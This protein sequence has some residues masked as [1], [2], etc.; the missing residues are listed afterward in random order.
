MGLDYQTEDIVRAEF[1]ELMALGP[2]LSQFLIYGPTPGTPLGERIDREGRWRRPFGEDPYRRWRESDG[3]TCVIE[4]PHMRPAQIEALQQWC[5]EQDY[6]RLG[7]SILRT[8]QVW[9]TCR[10]HLAGRRDAVHRVL[11][12]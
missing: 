10:D 1:E 7:P 5:Y 6:R 2:T 4:H 8:M 9:Q 11:H 12:R 3:F